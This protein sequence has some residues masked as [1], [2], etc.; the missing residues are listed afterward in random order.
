[1]LKRVLTAKAQRED[2]MT[3]SELKTLAIEEIYER[4][5]RVS[6]G[7][8]SFEALEGE[9]KIRL[10]TDDAEID[11]VDQRQVLVTLGVLDV[12]DADCVDL[13]Q[14]AMLHRRPIVENSRPLNPGPL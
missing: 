13:A 2:L 11:L 14:C 6:P 3:R 10:Q 4:L 5:A 7:S 8:V 9:L 1:M 12:V